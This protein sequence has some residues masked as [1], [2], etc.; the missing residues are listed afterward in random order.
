MQALLHFYVGFT[1]E[2]GLLISFGCEN[3]RKKE[4]VLYLVDHV[5]GFIFQLIVLFFFFV[6]SH[7][8]LFSSMALNDLLDPKIFVG[9]R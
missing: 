4:I 5:G 1:F 9:C 3:E 8:L 2:F 7:R 6:P